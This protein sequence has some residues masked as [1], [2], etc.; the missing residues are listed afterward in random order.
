MI[1]ES[2]TTGQWL[3]VLAASGVSAHLGL[4]MHGEWHM[5]IPSIV[6]GHAGLFAVLRLLVPEEAGHG[7]GYNL[8]WILGV[9]SYLVSL[10]SSM[11]IYRLFFHPLRKFPGPKFASVSKLWHV[12][13]ARNAKNHLVLEKVHQQYGNMARTGQ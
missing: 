9:A 13:Q 12:F 3:S 11:I 7:L 8:T 6:W 5:Y 4:F 10:F 1:T 2:Y